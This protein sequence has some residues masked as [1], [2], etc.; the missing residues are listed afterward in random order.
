MICGRTYVCGVSKIV[1][2]FVFVGIA[3]ANCL[4]S[5]GRCIVADDQLEALKSLRKDGFN[6]RVKIILS[7]EHW[8]ANRDSWLMFDS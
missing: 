2:S 4:G 7:I 3:S 6:D 8:K 5:V 1:N